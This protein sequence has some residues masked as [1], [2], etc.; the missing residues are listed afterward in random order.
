MS[1]S[2]TTKKHIKLD[3]DHAVSLSKEI[4]KV[5]AWLTGFEAGRGDKFVSIPGL[6]SLRQIQIIIAEA[7]K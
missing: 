7:C 2:G 4:G 5:R 6:D 3:R 1:K